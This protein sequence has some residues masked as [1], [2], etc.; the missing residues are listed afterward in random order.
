MGGDANQQ[1]LDAMSV[2]AL[3]QQG[4]DPLSQL[5]AAYQQRQK[6]DA[7]Q[8]V[9][10]L[11]QPS[12]ALPHPAPTPLPITDPYTQQ[13]TSPEQFSSRMGT[14]Q[15]AA[16]QPGDVAGMLAGSAAGPTGRAVLGSERGAVGEEGI[17]LIRGK[18]LEG[19]QYWT[20]KQPDGS[21]IGT[22]VTEYHPDKQRIYVTMMKTKGA[23]NARQMLQA[24]VKEHPEAKII[25]GD[26]TTG[27]HTGDFEYVIPGR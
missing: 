17:N 16:V 18:N 3:Q 21:E 2:A 7:L 1:R 23:G 8:A 14:V 10:Q 15:P 5:L 26:R 11:L 12:S 13:L 22:A 24:L 4:V 27:L 9:L 19:Q 25:A 20:A 6:P